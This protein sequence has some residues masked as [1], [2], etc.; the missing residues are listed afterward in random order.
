[1]YLLKGIFAFLKG[2]FVFIFASLR[3]TKEALD[4]LNHGLEKANKGME[5]FNKELSASKIQDERISAL[6]AE[7]APRLPVPPSR[8]KAK[9]E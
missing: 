4:A 9:A 6:E 5:E 1:M 8:E 7:L 2:F 3:F